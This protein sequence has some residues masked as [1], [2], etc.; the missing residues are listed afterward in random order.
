MKKLLIMLIIAVVFLSGCITPTKKE[1]SDVGLSTVLT[2]DVKKTTPTTPVTFIL[3]VK[4]LASE[5]AKEI[6]AQLLNLTG[7]RIENSL[8]NLDEL[9]PTDL[10]TFS[11]IAYAPSTPN[12]TFTPVANIFYKMETKAKLKLRV[13]DNDYL[14]TLKPEEREKIRG[15][16][17][18]LSSSIS[19]KTPV[20]VTLSLQQPF[21]LTGYSQ[22]F[23]F[24][25]EIKNVGLGEVY[26]D[27]SYYPPRD[28][29]KNYVRF[30][31]TGNS[32]LQCDFGDG[33]LV[34]LVNGSKSIVC[35]LIVTEDDVNKYSDFSADF[36]V[37]YSYLDKASTK[38]E[39]V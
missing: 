7:W 1:I 36:T 3:T 38:I 31:Y 17:A 22:R 18:L 27:D 16:S 24:V 37:G 14:N 21:I 23:P 30:G 33:D 26:S 5:S 28:G 11:W 10:Y 32:T 19:S 4:N 9:L 8:Q 39:V 29:E 2:S 12:K 35:R 34:K 15:K 13:Y 25:L 6:S 20:T